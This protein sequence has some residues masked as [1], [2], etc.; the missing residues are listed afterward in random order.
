MPW[1]PQELDGLLAIVAASLDEGG[2]IIEANAGFSRLTRVEGRSAAGA[3]VAD[4]FLMPNFETLMHTAADPNGEIHHGL[5][6]VGHFVGKTWTL[7]A[8]I[9]RVDRQIRILAEYDVEELENLNGKLQE[10]N[11]DYAKAQL[12][13][14]QTNL[15]LQQQ[16]A[17][18]VRLSLTDQLTGIGN[19]RSLDQAVAVEVSRAERSG[20]R[21]SVLMADLDHFKRVNDTYGHDAGDKVL[22][23]FGD[24]LRHQTRPTDTVTRYGGEE[25]VVLMPH[26]EIE[27]ASA[28]AERIR[29]ILAATTIPPLP[30]PV[31]ASFGVVELLAGE[32]GDAVLARVDKA[33][34]EAKNGGRNRVAVGAGR[35]SA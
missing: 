26:T 25:F 17:I 23:A 10:L 5:L 29:E 24:L 7:R 15:K 20:E 31:T 28:A 8:R 35:R 22:A 3:S 4:F 27:Y 6:T 14:A 1:Y 32:Q 12:E 16:E 11:D 33:L 9:W 18:I 2:R 30:T 19:R 34:F 13:L 21:L